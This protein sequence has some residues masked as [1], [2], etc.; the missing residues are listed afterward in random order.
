M[1]IENP[2]PNKAD[3]LREELAK[4]DKML[5]EGLGELDALKQQVGANKS[6]NT[7]QKEKEK[8]MPKFDT[9]AVA[10]KIKETLEKY[11]GMTEQEQKEK[12]LKILLEEKAEFQK[13]LIE[14]ENWLKKSLR[15]TEKWWKNLDKTRKGKLAKVAI[16]AGLI[17]AATVGIGM[18]TGILPSSFWSGGIRIMSRVG[19]ATGLNMALTSENGRKILEKFKKEEEEKKVGDIV[20]IEGKKYIILKEKI[21]NNETGYE[22]A[23]DGFIITK[24]SPRV[25]NKKIGDII[26]LRDGTENKITGEYTDKKYGEVYSI[27]E[28]TGEFISKENLQKAEKGLLKKIFNAGNLKYAALI[29]GA[30]VGFVLGGWMVAGVG[31]AGFA[32]KEYLNYS[33][34]RKVEELEKKKGDM[35]LENIPLD[36][37]DLAAHLNNFVKE[38]DDLVSELESSNRIKSIFSGAITIGTGLGTMA[39]AQSYHA[40]E[41]NTTSEDNTQNEKLNNGSKDPTPSPTKSPTT[42]TTPLPVKTATPV[43]NSTSTPPAQTEQPPVLPKAPIITESKVDNFVNEG[44]TIKNSQGGIAAIKSL[45]AQLQAEYPGQTAPQPIKDF[46]DADPTKKAME[47]GFYDPNN[48]TGAESALIQKGTIFKLDEKGELVFGTPDK[49]GDVAEW[50]T[51]YGGKMFDADQYRNTSKTSNVV[52][53]ERSESETV[54]SVEADKTES[55]VVEPDKKESAKETEQPLSNKPTQKIEEIPKPKPETQD[56]IKER[57]KAKIDDSENPKNKSQSLEDE[58]NNEQTSSEEVLNRNPQLRE[59]FEKNE[60]NLNDEQ[61]KAANTTFERVK[62]Q[63]PDEWEYDKDA[64]AK[65]YVGAKTKTSTVQ[66]LDKLQEVSGLKP[67]V[68]AVIGVERDETVAKYAARTIQKIAKD[69]NLDKIDSFKPETK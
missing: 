20:T 50:K 54:Q 10:E 52:M 48:K 55:E 59:N 23:R 14:N 61:F 21:E 66:Y 51:K 4:M 67:K 5:A 30:S 2:Q 46:I 69:G 62:A 17:G 12:A 34:K 45:Q 42:E 7:E 24:D 25:E 63:N 31:V 16:S 11:P 49:N 40:Q 1:S 29:G 18:G 9:T 28:T 36:I 3:I 43:P 60:Y 58:T 8:S 56:D 13:N 41:N 6:A 64:A 35:S 65:N 68:A 53:E 38:Y 26:I 57:I 37:N 47:L 19:V 32:L 33:A 22:V 39:A 44:I 15:N 27:V